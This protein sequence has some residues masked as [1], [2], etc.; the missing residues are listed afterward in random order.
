MNYGCMI[1]TL[2]PKPN[3]PNGKYFATIEE[4]KEKSKQELLV[5]PKRGF[6]KRFE[7]WKKRCHKCIISEGLL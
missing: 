6:Q 5:I 7:D 4:I 2:K 3:H 1:M